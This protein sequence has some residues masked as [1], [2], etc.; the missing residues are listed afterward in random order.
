MANETVIKGE[1]EKFPQLTVSQL[2]Q[3]NGIDL[4]VTD[5]AGNDVGTVVLDYFYGRL[6]VF[7][8]LPEDQEPTH[9]VH[10]QNLPEKGAGK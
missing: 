1:G 3:G 10:I 5:D 6:R 9:T 2:A 8:Y 7:V 4:I